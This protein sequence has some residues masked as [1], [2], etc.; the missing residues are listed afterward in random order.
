[1]PTIDRE[2]APDA[3]VLKHLFPTSTVGS[4]TILSQTFHTCTFVA[5]VDE[6]DQPARDIVVRLQVSEDQVFRLG[7]VSDLQRVAALAIPHLVPKVERTGTVWM[8]NGIEVEFSLT[9]FIPD[10]VTLESV[11][12][13]LSDD[14]RSAIMAELVAA[15]GKLYTLNRHNEQVQL[16]LKGSKFVLEGVN[17]SSESTSASTSSRLALGSP[18]IGYAGLG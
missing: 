10:S 5:R 4:T 17:H 9:T 12:D 13:D 11:W 14:E 3:N 8:E 1:M 18:H 15:M 6:I 7:T 2:L 16:L